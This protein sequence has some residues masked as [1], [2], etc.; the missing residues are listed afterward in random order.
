MPPRARSPHL[1]ER[2]LPRAGR[3]HDDDDEGRRHQRLAVIDGGMVATVP[4]VELPLDRLLRA[5]DLGDAE[6]LLR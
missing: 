1:D 4:D 3:A 2:R 6:R 5:A